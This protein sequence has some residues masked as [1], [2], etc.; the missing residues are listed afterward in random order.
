[1]I[2][3]KKTDHIYQSHSIAQKKIQISSFRN[4]SITNRTNKLYK[5][6]TIIFPMVH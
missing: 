1:M 4:D 2:I 3:K 5:K 6:N